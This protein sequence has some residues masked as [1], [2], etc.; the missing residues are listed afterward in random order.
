MAK[1]LTNHDPGHFH[2]FVGLINFLNIVVRFYLLIVNGDAG[3]GYNKDLDFIFV[4][5]MCLPFVTSYVFHHT[6]TMKQKSDP[7]TIW[8]EYR[9]HAAMFGLRSCFMLGLK[10]Y[11]KYY[12]PGGI[13][14]MKYLRIGTVLFSFFCAKSITDFYPKQVSTIRG[15]YKAG[16][17]V[18]IA[19]FMQFL[20][21]AGVMFGLAPEDYLNIEFGLILIIQLNAFNMTLRKKRISGPQTTKAFYT[22]LLS[23][24]FYLLVFRRFWNVPPTGFLDERLQFIYAALIAYSCRRS[25]CDR[26]T[27]WITAII[28]VC[29]M[30][31]DP[32]LTGLLK[33][34]DF[35][36][37]KLLMKI[38]N[39]F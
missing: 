21:S 18:T 15:M 29:A 9:A 30:F 24:G 17:E 28:T 27:S 12:V 4:F 36:A 5:I 34:E 31:G 35:G 16:L 11:E 7:F 2:A 20:A 6:P 10:L 26:F 37:S 23:C 39:S 25:G 33:G 13:P 1:L 38:Q 19:G 3:F 22:G 14:G 32:V 8:K